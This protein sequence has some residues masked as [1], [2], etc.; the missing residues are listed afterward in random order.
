MNLA[1]DYLEPEVETLDFETLRKDSI[2]GEELVKRVHTHIDEW[3]DARHQRFQ[4]LLKDSMSGEE[5]LN[6]AIQ[7]IE[8]VYATRNKQ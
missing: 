5:F 7:H 6:K 2:S 8:T 4:E 3:F 1:V